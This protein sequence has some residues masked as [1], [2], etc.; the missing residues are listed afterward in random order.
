MNAPFDF[1][2]LPDRVTIGRDVYVA[3]TAYVGGDVTLGDQCTVM[4][5][6]VIRGDVSA[7]R[8]GRRVN[9]QDATIIHTNRGVPLDIADDVS[10]GHRAIVHCRRVGPGTL[11]G[12]GSIILDDCEIG[13]GCLIAAGAVVPPKTIVP[14]GKVVMG[15][16]GRVVRD[17]TAAE[18]TY[19]QEVL[20]SY[21]HLGRLHAAGTYPN[22]AGLHHSSRDVHPT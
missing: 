20:A 11:V 14:D 13:A 15:V 5:H 4:H 19:I 3:P 8:I 9:V 18:R 7:I 21:L 6:V 2:D 12:I 1:V 10:I 22:R 17:T 16:P